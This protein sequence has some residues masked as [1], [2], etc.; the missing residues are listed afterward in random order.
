MKNWLQGKT[1]VLTGASRGIGR[2]LTK[3]FI[4]KYGARVIGI[5]RSEEKM[6]S[7]SEELGENA[8]NFS[9]RLFNVAEQEAWNSFADSLVKEGR[10]IALLVNNAGAFPAFRKIKNTPIDTV[11]NILKINYLAPMY[12]VNA[13]WTVNKSLKQ[14]EKTAVVNVCSSAALCTVVG[15]APYSASKA[16][17]KAYTEALQMEE[18]NTY[19]GIVYPGTT[20]TELFRNDENTQNSALDLI[21]MPAQ[22]MAKKIAKRIIKKRKRAV[23]GWD[24]KLMNWTVKIAPVKGL[25]LIA[26][27][28]KISKSKVFTNV[29]INEE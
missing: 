13:V 14:K 26:S 25:S 12:A 28:M 21:A 27:V 4:H 5:G 9:Y 6:S 17:L 18:R 22:R 3:I 29:F 24:A 8:I 11:E 10:S 15:T 16:A 20:K 23:V 19:I 7:L 2:E 1:V